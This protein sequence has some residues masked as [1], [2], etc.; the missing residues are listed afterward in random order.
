MVSM[1]NQLRS[2]SAVFRMAPVCILALVLSG[3][4]ATSGTT[5]VAARP[6]VPPTIARTPVTG[7]APTRTTSTASRAFVGRGVVTKVLVFVEEN[8]SI[9]QM[10]SGMPYT[11][12]LARRYAYATGYRAIT[13]PSLPNYVAIAGGQTYGISDDSSPAAHP[14]RGASVFGQAIAARKTAVVYADGMPG[15]CAT[16][17]G[18]ASYAVKHNPWAYFVGERA[19]CNRYDVPV[20]ALAGAI[21]RGTLPNVGMVVPNECN[22]AHD[23]SLGTA[24]TWFKGWMTKIF[25][26]PDWKSGHL[27]IVLTADEDDKSGP[28]TV[29]TVVIHPSQRA[30]VVTSALTHYSLTRLYEEVAHTRYLFGAASAPSM[31]T[32]FGLPLR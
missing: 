1:T 20:G 5:R 22:D 24:D 15:N 12:S 29:L 10:R 4:S 2:R 23:C 7:S 27:A 31:A 28:N 30:N 19:S 21:A 14:L 13:H 3:C 18:G 6:I 11:F 16:S 32:A 9:S 26:G 25:E 17:S 8:H